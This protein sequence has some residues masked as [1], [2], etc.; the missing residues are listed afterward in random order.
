MAQQLPRIF[1]WHFF[2]SFSLVMGEKNELF[3][4]WNS[5]EITKAQIDALIEKTISFL[6][7][8]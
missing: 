3:V 8:Q 1:P 5:K 6:K 4:E 7:Q 2:I